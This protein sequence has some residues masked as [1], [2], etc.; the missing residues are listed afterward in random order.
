MTVVEAMLHALLAQ[1]IALSLAVVAVR[2]LQALALR[3]LGAGAAYLCWLLVP[4]AMLAA[5]LPHAAADSMVVRVDVAAAAP[6]WVTATAS[7]ATSGVAWAG[8]VAVAW[9]AGALLLAFVLARRQSRFDAL[10]S[11][12][13]GASPRLPAGTGPAV[14]GLLRPRVALPDDFLTAFDDAE[15]R[16]MLAHEGVHLRRRDNLWNLLASA[17][18]VA[19][20][21]NPLAWWAARRLRVDQEQACDAAVLRREPPDALA[22]YAGA[23]LKVQ[24]VALTPPL[25]TAWQSSHPLVERVRMLQLHRLSPARQR[26]GL[27]LAALSIALAGAGG[28]ALR[29]GASAAPVSAE[30]SVMTDVD[31][32]VDAGTKVAVKVLSRTGE[33][34]AVRVDPDAAHPGTPVQIDFTV[35]RLDGDRLQ[36]DT[37]LRLGDP[38]A[39]VSSPSLVVHDGEAA[40]V[41]VKTIAGDHEIALS[42]LPRV[43]PGLPSASAPPSLPP[44]AAPALPAVP[45]AAALPAAPAQVPPPPQRAL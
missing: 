43:L 45:P 1:T 25:A 40:N 23:L 29:A 19:H 22:T 37:T 30:S 35:R 44:L 5:A 34:A 12:V 38:L 32:A 28:Y 39:K 31:V 21:F 27:R 9:A 18:L 6:R 41:R 36:I 33:Q 15:R 24:G 11:R 13:E 10:V 16:L 14:L 42:L 2:A 4:V 3:R 17:L 20:W 26:A 8:A 7:T